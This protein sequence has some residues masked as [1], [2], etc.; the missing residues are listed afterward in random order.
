MK[1]LFESLEDQKKVPLEDITWNDIKPFAWL[2]YDFSS[3]EEITSEFG[4]DRWYKRFI[5]KW[6][7][8]GLLVEIRPNK[9]KLEGNKKWDEYVEIS[10]EQ[11]SKYYRDK[12]SGGYTGD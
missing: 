6:E 2:P 9:W 3:S 1:Y 12:P 7:T 5:N 10:S 11:I 4:F 8:E